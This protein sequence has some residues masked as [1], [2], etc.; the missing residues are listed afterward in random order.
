MKDKTKKRKWNWAQILAIF[1]LVTLVVSMVYATV[2]LITAPSGNVPEGQQTKGDYS[3]ML[4]QCVLGVVVLFLPSIISKK[5]K[6]VIPNAMYIVFIVFLYC[7]IYLG[8][9]RSFYYL[10][11]NWDTIL[12]TFSGAMLGGLGF[13][14]VSLLNNDERITLSMSPAFVALFACSFAVFLGVFWE[15]YEFAADSF[16]MNMQK[17]MLEDG[18]MLQGHAAVADTM[19]DLFVDFLGAFVISIIGYFS[20]RKNKKWMKNFEFKKLDE[21][22]K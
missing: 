4:M 14:I 20:I 19:G 3:L 7:A 16:G 9:V 18:T 8:E 1:V 2:N 22:T 21:E 12:H 6:F 11:P 17:T 10:I 13:S 5:M 15:F